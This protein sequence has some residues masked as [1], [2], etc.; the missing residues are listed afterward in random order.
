MNIDSDMTMPWNQRS[1]L[2]T[3]TH[4]A[5]FEK[6]AITMIHA[7]SEKRKDDK[8]DEEAAKEARRRANESYVNTIEMLLNLKPGDK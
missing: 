1:W 2:D 4:N 3:F 5:A 6:H 8:A 7:M